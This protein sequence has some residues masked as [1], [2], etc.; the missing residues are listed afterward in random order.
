MGWIIIFSFNEVKTLVGFT[1]TLYLILGGVFYTVGALIYKLGKNIKYM[2]PLFHL[3]VLTGS[4]FH[5][6]SIFLYVIR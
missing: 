6:F 2:H 1:G 4:I 3:F 5:F